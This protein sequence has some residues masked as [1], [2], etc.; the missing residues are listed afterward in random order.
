MT[1]TT[2]LPE[3]AKPEQRLSIDEVDGKSTAIQKGGT[4]GDD[5]DMH[6][7]GKVQELRVCPAITTTSQRIL[8]SPSQRNFKFVGIVGFVTILQATWEST[9]LANYFGLF[10]G[11][12]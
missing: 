9:L 7:M 1:S 2:A 5:R 11:G 8:M 3:M 12:A 10:N 6:R 4:A